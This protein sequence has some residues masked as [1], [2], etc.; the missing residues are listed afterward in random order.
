MIEQPAHYCPSP[1]LGTRFMVIDRT[2]P[3]GETLVAQCNE[4]KLLEEEL[5][6]PD[7]LLMPLRLTLWPPKSAKP[8]G[9]GPC[10]ITDI[11]A[12]DLSQLARP[13]GVTPEG[14]AGIE[15]PVAWSVIDPETGIQFTIRSPLRAVHFVAILECGLY[16]QGADS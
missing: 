6:V 8:P 16:R 12:G 1:D 14:Y 4:Y 7:V 2:I 10:V 5:R 11:V 3:A 9:P 13:W 15:L